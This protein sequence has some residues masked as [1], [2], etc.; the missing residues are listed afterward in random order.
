MK[1]LSLILFG[2]QLVINFNIFLGYAMVIF[3]K[4]KIDSIPIERGFFLTGIMITINYILLSML[5]LLTIIWR[6]KSVGD[7]LLQV[8]KLNDKKLILKRLKIILKILSKMGDLLESA[9]K[10]F[11]FSNIF[12][13][14]NLF[15]IVLILIFLG[16]DILIHELEMEDKILFLAFIV[17]TIST[18]FCCLIIIISSTYFFNCF[19]NATNII[20][21]ICV[22]N[23][24]KKIQKFC[25]LGIL[26]FENTQKQISCGF[27]NFNWNQIFLMVSSI[28]SY[29]ITMIQFDYMLTIKKV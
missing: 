20:N 9:S 21:L 18:L 22:K 8:K 23:N 6:F 16:Y 1:I 7:A 25:E 5:L 27:Y 17:F 2:Y 26:Q 4:V 13:F 28:F 14:C 12:L 15:M 19:G 10:Y 11:L 29:I 3:L 24:D